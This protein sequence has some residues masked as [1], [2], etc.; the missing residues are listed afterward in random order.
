MT[1]YP[2]EGAGRKRGLYMLNY[3]IISFSYHRRTC[4]PLPSD[5]EGRD[6]PNF[7]LAVSTPQFDH[8]R[9]QPNAS[10]NGGPSTPGIYSSVQRWRRRSS[11]EVYV[12][13]KL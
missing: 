1:Y 9:V 4:I 13:A 10:R 7:L 3:V 5:V 12:G 8:S 11:A 6:R 2:G